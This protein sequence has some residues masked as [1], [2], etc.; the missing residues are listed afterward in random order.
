MI[1]NRLLYVLDKI[2]I[3]SKRQADSQRHRCS[4]EQIVCLSQRMAFRKCKVPFL[5]L[6]TL[7]MHLGE[8]DFL[9]CL[10]PVA[11]LATYI[12]GL[13]VCDIAIL[14]TR[15]GL[16]QGA[17]LSLIVFNLMIND[18]IDLIPKSVPGI[19]ILLLADDMMMSAT[20]SDISGLEGVLLRDLH[21]L[22][23]WSYENNMYV[24]TFAASE[25]DVSILRNRITK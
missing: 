2:G 10:L 22:Y 25:I 11:F 14:Q 5:C 13:R 4:S 1:A 7:R 24:N 9:R 6:W 8:L 20:G 18:L 15:Q 16:P 12:N 3:I 19:N 23:V 17:V 21:V